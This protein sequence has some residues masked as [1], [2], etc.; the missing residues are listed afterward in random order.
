M[1]LQD[2]MIVT[3]HDTCDASRGFTRRL[4]KLREL[5]GALLLPVVIPPEAF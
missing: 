2:V 1:E 5:Y 4:P 3:P